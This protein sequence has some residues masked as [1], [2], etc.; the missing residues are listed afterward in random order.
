M[1][2]QRALDLGAYGIN[3]PMVNT[4]AGAEVVVQSIR[5][6]PVGARSWGPIR[7]TL[8]GGPDYF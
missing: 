8:Y 4:R 2:T 1:Y 5:Y 3:V 7:G 6:P